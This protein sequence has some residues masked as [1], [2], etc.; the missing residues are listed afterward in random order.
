MT[1]GNGD[2][3]ME[4]AKAL[5]RAVGES[6]GREMKAHPEIPD[7]QRHG[8][9]SRSVINGAL[10]SVQWGY[11]RTHGMIDLR[12]IIIGV[13]DYIGTVIAQ[14]GSTP[15][16]RAAMVE[17]LFEV[18]GDSVCEHSAGNETIN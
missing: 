16:L 14:A 9:F 13:G 17:H 6:V 15:K 2:E 18:V 4:A 12:D 1:M 8:C 3:Q 7:D 11:A 5:L 10:W